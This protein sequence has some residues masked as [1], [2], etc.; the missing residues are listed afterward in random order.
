MALRQEAVNQ[1]AAD[2]ACA[3]GNE[4]SFCHWEK[5]IYHEDTKTRSEWEEGLTTDNTKNTE[6]ITEKN[7]VFANSFS[8]GG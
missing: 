3:A 6:E 8:A 4:E 5:L 2:E 7:K 1:I